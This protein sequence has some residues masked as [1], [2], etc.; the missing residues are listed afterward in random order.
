LKFIDPDFSEDK[1][2]EEKEK[3]II[4]RHTIKIS[5]INKKE[6]DQAKKGCC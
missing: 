5:P 6:D 3:E 4:R 1:T 2:E